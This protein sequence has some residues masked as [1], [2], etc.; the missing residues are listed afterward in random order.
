MALLLLMPLVGCGSRST[1]EPNTI[2]QSLLSAPGDENQIFAQAANPPPGGEF[3]DGGF[4]EHS[5]AVVPPGVNTNCLNG[6][7]FFAN[8]Q[9]LINGKPT[10]VAAVD[11]PCVEAGT[12]TPS[13]IDSTVFSRMTANLS[14]PGH[15]L[16]DVVD[17]PGPTISSSVSPTTRSFTSGVARR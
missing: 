7:Y 4:F 12:C 2:L 3:F 5:S 17:N 13:S 9:S 14:I 16:T 1:S 10:L 6:R 15:W 8:G 11:L